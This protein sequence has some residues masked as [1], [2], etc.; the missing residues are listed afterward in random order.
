M[1]NLTVLVRRECLLTWRRPVEWLNPL[2]FFL[3]VTL[4]LPL[5]LPPDIKILKVIGPSLVWVAALLALL[6]SLNRLFQPDFED[7][8]LEQWFFSSTPFS[9]LVFVKIAI[10]WLLL[11]VPLFLFI[12][13]VALMFHLSTYVME[14][15]F[16]TLLLGTPI[17]ILLGSI[18]AAITISL[19]QQGLLLAL[20]VIPLY[21]PTLIFAT[22]ALQ[23]A[24]TGESITGSLA[25]LAA[26]LMLAL[27][28]AP[29]LTAFCLRLGIAFK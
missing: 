1:N 18:G 21:I 7:G 17:L 20:I 14:V 25:W 19:P 12:P 28:L 15:L 11:T 24:N 26:L 3:L 2:L 23:A 8:S 22:Q 16:L 6:L 13:I 27:P 9:L 5:A 4:L 10:H 29:V